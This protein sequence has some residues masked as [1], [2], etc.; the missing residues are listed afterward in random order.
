MT[1]ICINHRINDSV[2]KAAQMEHLWYYTSHIPF[3]I[4]FQARVKIDCHMSIYH[5]LWFMNK[6][7]Y[8]YDYKYLCVC[9]YIDK[10]QLPPASY[11]YKLYNCIIN[12]YDILSNGHMRWYSK[13]YCM[14][15]FILNCFTLRIWIWLFNN[16]TAAKWTVVQFY[17]FCHA[18]TI[19]HHVNDFFH[20]FT[21]VWAKLTCLMRYELLILWEIQ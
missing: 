20:Y 2:C 14:L 9:V 4:C 6:N 12:Q 18:C 10:K 1:T 16:T 7:V 8:V 19:R 21:D 11:W 17:P 5:S 13:S 15:Y 3:I